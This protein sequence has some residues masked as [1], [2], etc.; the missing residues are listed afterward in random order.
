MFRLGGAAGQTVDYA[1]KMARMPEERMMNKVMAAGGMD[2]ALLARIVAVLAPFYRAAATGPEIDKFG[3]PA[4]VGANFRENFEQTEQFVGG[5]ALGQ[6]QFATI[7]AYAD[8]FLGQTALFQQ[9]LAEGRIRDGHGDLHSANICLADQVYIFDCIEFNRRLRY[10][11]VASDIA[12]LA[13]D[14]DYHGLAALADG[15]VASFVGESGDPGL[16]G[17]L[18]FYKCYRAYVRGK[19][20]LLTGQAP[21]IDEAARAA[22]LAQAARYFQLAVAYAEAR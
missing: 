21:E 1:L 17:V 4:A 15:F 5:P 7:A 9:R 22:G 16:Y 14:L 11:D 20:G 6:K 12:F 8:K 3:T 10:C 13:M 2:S 19:I 18:N